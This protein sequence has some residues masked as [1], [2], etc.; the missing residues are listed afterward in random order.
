MPNPDRAQVAAL[1]S[2]KPYVDDFG[3]AHCPRCRTVDGNGLVPACPT[4]G[5]TMN[6]PGAERSSAVHRERVNG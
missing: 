4:C 5:W 1:G 2:Q 6:E 3:G